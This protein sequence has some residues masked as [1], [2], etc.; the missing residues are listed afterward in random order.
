MKK[1]IIFI[2]L[3]FIIS[4]IGYMGY[5]TIT[6]Y[7][8]KYNE[9]SFKDGLK[10][11]REIE[12][13]FNFDQGYPEDLDGKW[14]MLGYLNN[15]LNYVENLDQTNDIRALYYY[16]MF[17]TRELKSKINF[18]MATKYK[19]RLTE[20]GVLICPKR[21]FYDQRMQNFNKS[22]QLGNEAI[23]NINIL[24]EYYP[25][26]FEL[27]KIER[28]TPKLL[29]AQYYQI[30]EDRKEEEETVMRLCFT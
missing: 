8:I 20:V 15:I 3:I 18:Q 26:H 12:K 16:M 24:I 30:E 27:T 17:R 1:I 14:S 28:I 9:Y 21:A 7:I 23:K 25:K 10:E 5:P 22:V 6:G 19:L 29:E 2:I 4:M 13:D 11:V